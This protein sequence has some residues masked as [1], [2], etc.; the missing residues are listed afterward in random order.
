[1]KSLLKLATIA[2]LLMIM[3]LAA[4]STPPQPVSREQYQTALNEATE[5]E[6]TA[7][8]NLQEM[9]NLEAE[10]ARKEAELRSLKDYERQLGN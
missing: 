2:L 10:L 9:R 7:D 6:R 1:M 4:C 3:L 5:A 8:Q